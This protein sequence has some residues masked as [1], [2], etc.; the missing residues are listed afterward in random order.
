[1]SDP[2]PSQYRG[3][4]APSPT[5]PLHF[6]SLVAAVG[7]Y[8]HAKK[9]G[10][11]WLVRIEDL[12]PPR[13]VPGATDRILHTLEAFGFTWDGPILYQSNR[14]EVYEQALQQ[15]RLQGRSYPC[16]C[17]RSELQALRSHD[18]DQEELHYPGLCRH[19]PLSNKEPYAWRFRVPNKSVHFYDALQGEHHVDLNSSIGDFVIKRRDGWFA[20]QL[21]VVVDDAAQGITEVVRGAD[22]LLNTPR[23]IALQQALQLEQPRYAHLPVATDALGKKLGKST[24]ATPLNASHAAQNLWQ[25]LHFLHQAP[26]AE[27]LRASPDSFWKWAIAH[28]NPT[29]MRNLLAQ[30]ID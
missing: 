23:Q 20:Y 29:P 5:G 25:A 12:D 6:G 26:P 11:Q 14:S 2:Q 9:A 22:L 18:T 27:L 7:S 4:F 15:L 10:G 16:S 17:S 19:G 13:V 21:A 28:W 24:A 1:M 3:R 30:K 8:L